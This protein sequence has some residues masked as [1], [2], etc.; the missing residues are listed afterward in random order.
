[1]KTRAWTLFAGIALALVLLPHADAITGCSNA[2]LNG[3]FAMQFSGIISPAGGA[4]GG[5]PIQPAQATVSTGSTP[6]GVAVAGVARLY[7]DGAGALYGYSS[8]NARGLWAQGNLTGSYSVNDDCTVS[9][10]LTDSAGNSQNFAGVVAGQGSTALVLQTDA[11]T[12]ITGT[13]KRLRGFCDVS[14]AGTFG[15]QYAASGG[16]G[17]TSTGVISFDGQGNAAATESRFAG[18]TA[19]QVASS[20]TIAIN[21]DCTASLLLVSLTDGSAVNF[22][23]IVSADYSQISLVRSDPG[24]VATGAVIAQ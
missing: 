1:M 15:L 2:T 19:S 23:G 9:F 24:S 21:P 5:V 4:V 7:L 17:A 3:N 10:S 16:S 6:S 20:G 11:N 12:G 22:A 8:V 13:I 18:G 14:L